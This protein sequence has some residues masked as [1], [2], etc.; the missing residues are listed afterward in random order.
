MGRM[1]AVREK[2]TCSSIMPKMDSGASDEC[3][4]WVATSHASSI[5]SG[6]TPSKSS[7]GEVSITSVNSERIDS[8]EASPLTLADAEKEQWMDL[9]LTEWV[10]PVASSREYRA[11]PLAFASAARTTPSMLRACLP[12]SNSQIEPREMSCTGGGPSSSRGCLSVT[13]VRL[14]SP[15][16]RDVYG[17]THGLKAAAMTETRES[18]ITG[19]TVLQ[20]EIESFGAMARECLALKN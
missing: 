9:P 4:D 2:Q 16:A 1:G 12:S 7:T 17:W 5:I 10:L 8:G 15:T 6:F 13:R 11:P 20:V 19:W 14:C 3:S 18:I